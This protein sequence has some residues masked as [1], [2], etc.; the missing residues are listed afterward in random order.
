MA[1]AVGGVLLVPAAYGRL[2][3]PAPVTTNAGA[4]SSPNSSTEAAPTPATPP[5]ATPGR[6]KPSPK[7][8]RRTLAAGR[9][10]VKLGQE[11]FSYA[12]LDRESGKVSGAN[13]AATSS[14][15]S[16]IKVWIVSDYLR[17]LGDE[18]PPP[19]RLT[20]ASSAIRDSDDAAAQSLFIAGGGAS[21]IDRLTR[22]CR[23]RQTRAVVPAGAAVV[24]WSYTEMSA[25]DAVRM[26]ECVKNGT[27]AGPRWTNWVLGQMAKVR[28]STAARDQRPTSGG[29]RWGI[30]DGL[31]EEILAQGP[32]GIKNGWTLHRDDGLWHVNC[33]AVADDWILAVLLRYPGSQDLDRGAG[34]CA[35]VAEQLVTPRQKTG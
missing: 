25:T 3:P 10:S 29:G 23:L 5:S 4:T 31:P 9:V 27:A 8:Q 2:N 20:E 18:E 11:F 12:L 16:M 14:T 33:L 21:V 35:S 24:W 22:T 34:I 7:S 15:E 30:I 26:G 19:D 1:I 28:G 17:R 13:L 6:T 32:V